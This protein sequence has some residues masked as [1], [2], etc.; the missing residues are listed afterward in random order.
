MEVPKLRFFK[1]PAGSSRETSEQAWA[2]CVSEFDHA[3]CGLPQSGTWEPSQ[4]LNSSLVRVCQ[5]SFA[6][7]WLDPNLQM[8]H[9]F[10]G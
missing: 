1:R 2:R 6:F 7:E 9:I 3:L 5:L 10:V 8:H 4:G